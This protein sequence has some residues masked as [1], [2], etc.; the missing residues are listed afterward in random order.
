VDLN[1]LHDTANQINALLTSADE[2]ERQC[3]DFRLRAGRLLLE[4]KKLVDAGDPAANGMKWE[5]W[6]RK[7]ITNPRTTKP[8][9]QADI[10]KMMALARAADPAAARAQEKRKTREHAAKT[11]APKDPVNEFTKACQEAKVPPVSAVQAD[12]SDE[13]LADR[14]RVCWKSGRD[15]YQSMFAML[16]QVRKRI[17]DEELPRWC[18]DKLHISFSIILEVMKVLNRFDKARTKADFAKAKQAEKDQR[19]A[20]KKQRRAA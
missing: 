19:D 20:N 2:A 17:G 9:S 15:K 11:R 7:V 10:R 13:Q 6:C 16:D 18:M 8:R 5:N 12:Q 3:E 4:A 1:P 14:I